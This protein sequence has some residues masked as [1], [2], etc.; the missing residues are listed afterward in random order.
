MS[1]AEPAA[2]TRTFLEKA[3]QYL[4][5][6]IDDLS[7]GRYNPA[8]SNA[9][10][11]GINA[12]D[13]ICLAAT[14]SYSTS[15]DHDAALAVLNRAGEAGQRAL[16]LLQALLPQKNLSQYRSV[17]NTRDEAEAAVAA[18]EELLELARRAVG[19]LPGD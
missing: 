6:A 8:V 11:S 5:S 4:Q 9:V 7:A 3:T 12:S 19:T 17:L 18:A 2:Q 10:V 13:V 16:P 1:G 14:G 15:P